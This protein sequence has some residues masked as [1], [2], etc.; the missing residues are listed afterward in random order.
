MS[1]LA[2]RFVMACPKTRPPEAPTAA[3]PRTWSGTAT[4]ARSASTS[5]WRGYEMGRPSLLLLRAQDQGEKIEVSVG[6][7]VILVAE[8]TL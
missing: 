1:K 4:T 3:W 2:F 7:K 6:G 5:V 8:G